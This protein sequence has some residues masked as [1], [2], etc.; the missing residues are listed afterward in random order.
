MPDADANAARESRAPTPKPP[1]KV[2]GGRIS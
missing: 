1:A 2:A